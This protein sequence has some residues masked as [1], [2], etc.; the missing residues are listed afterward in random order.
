[1]SLTDEASE[2]SI[3]QR[4]PVVDCDV[5]TDYTDSDI[6][7]KRAQY[8]DEP[9]KSLMTSDEAFYN[10][11]PSDAFVK[12]IPDKFSPINMK[13]TDPERDIQEALCSKYDID[14]ALI[15]MLVKFDT[16]PETHRAIQEMR[17]VNNVLLD[18]FL[19]GQ[20]NLYGYC[21]ISTRKPEESAEELD[22]MGKEDQIVGAMILNGASERPMGDSRYDM[23]YRAAED[24]DLPI[25]F[26]TSGGGMPA[27]QGHPISGQNFER[28]L[29]VHALSHPVVHMI[30]LTSLIYEGVP[31]KFPDLDFVFLEA[32]L[33]WI[34]YMM[35]R[36]NKE[37]VQRRFDAPLLEK[38]PEEYIRDRFYFG[39]QPVE[40]PNNPDH[41]KPII[42]TIGADSILFTTDHPHFDFD[43]PSIV[44]DQYFDHLSEEDQE[45]VLY[46]NATDV[47]DLKI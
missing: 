11:Y 27:Q 38:S 17:A 37:Y 19:H 4:S 12:S 3:F 21:M 33:S 15:N 23:I 29:P 20:D 35:F 14:Y 24:N 9:Y 26:H 45:Q 5:H 13:V 40:E 25:T 10:P 36:L 1:M 47:F 18:H 6:V 2:P 34:P 43:N 39:T 42:D 7:E 22:R 28:F 32:G 8:L 44:F 41:L 46:G 30:T 16:A 31:V